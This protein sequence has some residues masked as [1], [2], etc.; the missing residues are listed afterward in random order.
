M[1][2]AWIVSGTGQTQGRGG[3]PRWR[4]H[5]YPEKEKGIL[6]GR[7]TFVSQ[8]PYM[9]SQREW[10]EVCSGK[11]DSWREIYREKGGR[12]R[13]GRWCRVARWGMTSDREAGAWGWAWVCTS[14]QWC[15]LWLSVVRWGSVRGCRQHT[16]YLPQS[17]GSVTRQWRLA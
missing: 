4:P 15:H 1:T 9:K 17:F 3:I 16:R 10:G 13:K 5:S 7:E 14:H 8:V 12:G 6:W 11:G 2:I